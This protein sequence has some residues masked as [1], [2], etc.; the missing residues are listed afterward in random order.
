MQ[1][2][3]LAR[4]SPTAVDGNGSGS[5]EQCPQPAVPP[6]SSTSMIPSMGINVLGNLKPL[7]TH[8]LLPSY[9]SKC[10]VPVRPLH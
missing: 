7:G 5:D 9:T 2:A 6:S 3:M 1:A 8:N 4:T 10:Q